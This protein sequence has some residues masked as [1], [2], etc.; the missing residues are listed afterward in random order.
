MKERMEKETTPRGTRATG[1]PA[2]P[3]RPPAE[4]CDIPIPGL[5]ANGPADPFVTFWAT[6]KSYFP[7][8]KM[9]SR[10]IRTP[11]A[12][13][14]DRETAIFPPSGTDSSSGASEAKT[15]CAG[16]AG[17][18]SP[19]YRSRG[20]GR[21]APEPMI[22]SGFPFGGGWSVYRSRENAWIPPPAVETTALYRGVLTVIHRW[23]Y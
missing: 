3:A 15:G 4:P 12:D 20:R 10:S 2:S 1:E 14:Q 17:W 7:P 23:G 8:V 11:S 21:I 5:G 13:C 19:R 22:S 9:Y 6:S 16:K 18:L